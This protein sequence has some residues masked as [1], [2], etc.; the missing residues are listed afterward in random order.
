M[1]TWDPEKNTVLVITKAKDNKLV[2]FTRQ[3]AEWLIFTPQFGKKNP[4]IV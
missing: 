2:A 3:L 4:F 1:D